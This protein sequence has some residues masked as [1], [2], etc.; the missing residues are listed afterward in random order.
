MT[1]WQ[2]AT[3]A[4]IWEPSVLVGCAALLGL[5]LIAVR[6]RISQRA[7]SYVAGLG[8]LLIALLSPL[9]VLGDTYL[10]SAHMVQHLLLVLVVPPL[11]LLGIPPRLAAKVLDWPPARRLERLLAQPVVAWLLG[12]GFVWIWHVP[13]LYNAALAH[14]TLHI[15]EHL[16]FLVTSTIFWW[17]VCSPLLAHRLSPPLTLIYLMAAGMANT[18]LGIFLAFLPVLYPAYLHPL[19]SLGIL[20]LLRGQWGLTPAVDQQLGGFLMWV[21]GSFPYLAG[22]VMAFMRWQRLSEAEL[23]P[24]AGAGRP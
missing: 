5:Y 8:V 22:M 17:P 15:V 19:D 11:L 1:T 6:G 16:C 9:E 21:P 12:I 4:W 14:E 24:T 3:S 23:Q 13:A 7:W 18:L 20:P 10:F 2:I